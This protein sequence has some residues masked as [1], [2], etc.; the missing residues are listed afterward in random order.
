ME[1][2]ELVLC[3]QPISWKNTTGLSIRLWN[4]STVRRKDSKFETTTWLRCSSCKKGCF[5]VPIYLILGKRRLMKKIS[6]LPTRISTQWSQELQ[7][8]CP[9]RQT[10]GESFGMIS[11]SKSKPTAT[12]RPQWLDSNSSHSQRSKIIRPNQSW[13]ASRTN[14]FSSDSQCEKISTCSRR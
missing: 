12:S 9:P 11:W 3:L 2:Q 1:N 4:L 13:K 14:S 6:S 10:K 5:R 8:L 7:S